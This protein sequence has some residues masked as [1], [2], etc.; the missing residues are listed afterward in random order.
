[1]NEWPM[2]LILAEA[3]DKQWYPGLGPKISKC[4]DVGSKII[5]RG[6]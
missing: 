1:M 4:P 3:L 2:I 6:I 5:P